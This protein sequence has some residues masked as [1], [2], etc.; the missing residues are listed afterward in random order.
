[1]CHFTDE[2]KESL[3]GAM[4][5]SQAVEGLLKNNLTKAIEYKLIDEQDLDKK[6]LGGL[7]KILKE[8][9]LQS[10]FIETHSKEEYDLIK[11]LYNLLSKRNHLVHVSFDACFHDILAPKCEGK[12]IQKIEFNKQL[13]TNA[14]TVFGYLLKLDEIM[15]SEKP[16]PF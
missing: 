2:Y 7:I 9:N 15:N 10:K 5:W 16:A 1:M 11:E 6:T 3:F 12:I 13:K 8:S 14:G 4:L